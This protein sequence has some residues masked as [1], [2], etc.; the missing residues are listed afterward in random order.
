MSILST[1]KLKKLDDLFYKHIPKEFEEVSN[2]NY[3]LKQFAEK[4]KLHELLFGEPNRTSNQKLQFEQKIIEPVHATI[5]DDAPNNENSTKHSDHG[6]NLENEYQNDSIVNQPKL[7]FEAIRLTFLSKNTFVVQVEAVINQSRAFHYLEEVPALIL[8]VYFEFKDKKNKPSKRIKIIDIDV[9]ALKFIEYGYK[10]T[11][12]YTL[13]N[14]TTSQDYYESL[15]RE[16]LNGPEI[17]EFNSEAIMCINA[18]VA[19][20]STH[21]KFIDFYVSTI[22]LLKPLKKEIQLF[23]INTYIKDVSDPYQFI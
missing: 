6:H 7:S 9:I 4:F 14:T 3:K 2:G 23:L 17:G 8:D 13:D 10:P 22:P 18:L 15:Y 12:V 20:K 5:M 21:K 19:L 1:K 11:G 16:F